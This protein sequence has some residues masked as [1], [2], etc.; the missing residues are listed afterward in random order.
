[1]VYIDIIGSNNFHNWASDVSSLMSDAKSELDS[2]LSQ[3]DDGYTIRTWPSDPLPVDPNTCDMKKRL[4]RANKNLEDGKGPI[5]NSESD[6]WL[7][8]DHCSEP[9]GGGQTIVGIS[10]SGTAGVKTSDIDGE[11]H[12]CLVDYEANHTC[13]NTGGRHQTNA[14]E[15]A[16]GFTACHKDGS[17]YDDDTF[18]LMEIGDDEVSQCV[19][20]GSPADCLA[21]FSLCSD[22]AI[23][24]RM[25]D[26]NSGDSFSIE[27][28]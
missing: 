27:S 12:A 9:L 5:A 21:S 14:H 10:Y 15:V 18:T 23:T 6:Y 25:D 17:V 2:R 8:L 22:N 20:N 24:K 26:I 19:N 11:G 13:D 1:M 7:V 28:C 16:H 3:V 4:E